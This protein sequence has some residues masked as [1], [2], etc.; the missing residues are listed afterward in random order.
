[1]RKL[2]T[3]K[4]RHVLKRTNQ[5]EADPA[6]KPKSVWCQNPAHK[7]LLYYFPCLVPMCL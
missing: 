3:E 1:M 6:F 2:S 7:P 4:I 5:G